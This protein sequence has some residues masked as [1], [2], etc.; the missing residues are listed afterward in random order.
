VR[1]VVMVHL[2]MNI[3]EQ[4][5]YPWAPLAKIVLQHVRELRY[6]LQYH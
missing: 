2:V 5:R 3:R 1:I 4:R 6:V